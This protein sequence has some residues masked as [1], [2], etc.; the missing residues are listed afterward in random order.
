[1]GQP[2]PEQI[3]RI[4][5]ALGISGQ[6]PEGREKMLAALEWA[7]SLSPG[8][9]F[10]PGY[11]PGRPRPDYR[12]LHA[13]LRKAAEKVRAYLDDEDLDWWSVGTLDAIISGIDDIAPDEDKGGRPAN[14][15][16]QG[17]V[18]GLGGLYRRLT[19]REPALS[20]DVHNKPGG[21]FFVF[22]SECLRVFEPELALKSD[23][24]LASAIRR[25]L[26]MNF[27]P[28]V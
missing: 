10:G 13:N 21:P 4:E 20:R 19:D 22:V 28:T 12:R 1:M 17:A 11:L 6:S 18:H 24:A 16:L 14:L 7:F 25:T 26:K 5:A 23:E 8:E 15:R 2:T 27:R 3:E 9:V